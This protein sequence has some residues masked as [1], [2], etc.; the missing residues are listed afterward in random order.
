MTDTVTITDHE[1]IREWVSAR[2]GFPAIR[3]AIPSVGNTDAVL[4][5]VFDQRAYQDQDDG[6]DRGAGGFQQVEW[7]EWFAIFDKK[8]LA[9]VVAEDQPGVRE[10]FYELIAR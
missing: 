6:Q 7:D 9:L 2:S 4:S 3:D 5:L 8:G 10:N 1:D